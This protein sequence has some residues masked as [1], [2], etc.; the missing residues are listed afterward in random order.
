MAARESLD[1]DESGP[2]DGKDDE[3]RDTI[4]DRDRIR[5][6]AVRVEKSDADLAAIAGI[7]RSRAVYNGDAVLGR[8]TAARNHEGDVSIGQRDRDPSA[9][10]R[11]LSRLEHELIGR[12]EV[13]TRVP[14]VRITRHRCCRNQHLYGISHPPRLVQKREAQK[15]LVKW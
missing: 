9:D 8:Q 13:S 14:R 15:S 10:C 3:L 11:S 1:G 5:L 7:H 6:C 12:Y 4:T 2:R